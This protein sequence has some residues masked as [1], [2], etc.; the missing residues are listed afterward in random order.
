[1]GYQSS[2]QTLNKKLS[3]ESMKW[4]KVE[5][6]E[7]VAMP[8]FWACKGVSKAD[9]WDDSQSQCKRYGLGKKN[10]KVR[11]KFNFLQILDNFSREHWS[12][13]R[14]VASLYQRENQVHSVGQV[15]GQRLNTKVKLAIHVRIY[16]L[17][18]TVR[19]QT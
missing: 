19:I 17:Y 7:T 14:F 5:W 12:L 15:E 18:E 9:N 6:V 3:K 13:E 11:E 16:V 8:K 10:T 2:D 1:M 4:I